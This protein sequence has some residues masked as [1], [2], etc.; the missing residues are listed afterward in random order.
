MA[1]P[2]RP[3]PI[4]PDAWPPAPPLA[5]AVVAAVVLG[6]L[7]WVLQDQALPPLEAA[8]AARVRWLLAALVLAGAAAAG[9]SAGWAAAAARRRALAEAEAER[10]AALAGLAHE[11]RNPLGGVTFLAGALAEEVAGTPAAAQAARLLDEAA[12]LTRLVEAALDEAR[13]RAP[14]RATVALAPLLA[15]VAGLVRPLADAR[16]VEVQVEGAG[17]ALGDRD[18]LRRAVLN[19]ARNAV[20]A[21]PDNGVVR[22][23]GRAGAAEEGGGAVVEVLDRGPGLDP[24]AR[25]RLFQPF[26]TTRAQG[27]GLGLA[28]ARRVAEAHGG[29]LALLPREGGG[30]VARL[31]LP[32]R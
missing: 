3:D 4:P 22:L 13:A 25:A 23:T 19:L 7:A 11:V 18:Q 27:L 28:L 2:E 29:T 26:A 14:V 32:G 12:A 20:E 31:S 9:L 10:A 8:E 5:A 1:G 21:S 30:T 6:A 16:G 24:A 15:E 17:E